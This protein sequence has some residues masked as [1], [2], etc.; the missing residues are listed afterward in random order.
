MVETQNDIGKRQSHSDNVNIAAAFRYAYGRAKLW[1]SW[2]WIL[3][4]I[5]VVLQLLATINHQYLKAYLPDDIVA[6]VVFVSLAS[7]LMATLGRHL[8]ISSNIDLGSKLQ[9][10]HDFQVLGLG[11]KPTT[12]EVSR[13]QIDRLSRKWLNKEPQ[14]LSNISEWWPHCVSELPK[15]PGIALCLFSTFRWEYEL[16]R[17]YSVV[18]IVCGVA[19]LIGSLALMHILEYQIAEYIVRIFT[20]FSPMFAL[21][22]E[23]I[24]LNST[25]VNVAK[26]S[27]QEALNIWNK[28]IDSR[29]LDEDLEDLN[30]LV[31]LWAG[32][33][34]SASPIFDW[35][36]WFTQKVMNEDMIVDATALVAEYKASRAKI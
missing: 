9:R 27:S 2:I 13:S 21:L 29:E 20:P 17:K 5:L 7:M 4:A 14:D 36:Y 26:G 10:L 31:F 12:L 34:A 33:R 8:F 32:Y 1:K 22:V 15:K 16:R 30:Q 25:C 35:L 11:V 23:E 28:A 18:L 6:M 19:L 24:L 3:T